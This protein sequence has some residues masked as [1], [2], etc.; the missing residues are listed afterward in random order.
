MTSFRYNGAY[1]TERKFLYDEHKHYYRVIVNG[2]EVGLEK[3][4]KLCYNKIRKAVDR[5]MEIYKFEFGSFLNIIFALAAIGMLVVTAL[6][7]KFI[8]RQMKN[9]LKNELKYFFKR[10]LVFIPF[11]IIPLVF[12]I[13]F[14]TQFVKYTS[15]D[16]HMEKGNTSVLE[17]D[18]TVV[19]VEEEYYRGSFSGYNV[20][21]EIEGQIISPANTFSKEVV[22]AFESNQILIIQYGEI[23]NDGTYI[24][25]I[26]TSN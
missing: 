11:V 10:I 23:K 14:A 8:A 13:V 12:S 9:E 22:D 2:E 26:K 15:W 4:R 16:Y 6:V 17:G 20:V 1:Q 5:F 24:W 3:R 7:V 21:I 25:S 19:S 18:I